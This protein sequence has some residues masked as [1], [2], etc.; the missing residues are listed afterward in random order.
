M[1]KESNEGA[2]IRQFLKENKINQADLAAKMGLSRQGLIWH[3][4]KEKVDYEFKMKLRQAGVKMFDETGKLSSGD[5]KENNTHNEVKLP[6]TY[7]E[8]VSLYK[9]VISALKRELE[10]KDKYILLLESRIK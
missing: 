5:D 1:K 9:E 8:L 2:E 7:A 6:T 4:D 10:I 3:L